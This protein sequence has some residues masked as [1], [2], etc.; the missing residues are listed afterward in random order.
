MPKAVR[1]ELIKFGRE[2]KNIIEQSGY[3]MS[4][5]AEKFSI[6]KTIVYE[7]AK[8]QTM[9]GAETLGAIARGLSQISGKKITV[10]ELLIKTGLKEE[11]EDQEELRTIPNS[12]L[13]WHVK[14]KDNSDRADFWASALKIAADDYES[15]VNLENNDSLAGSVVLP[16][17]RSQMDILIGLIN[18]FA[19][20]HKLEDT[21]DI[22][23]WL[24]DRFPEVRSDVKDSMIIG[25]AEILA[26]KRLPYQDST[27]YRALIDPLAKALGYDNDDDL[28]DYC[29]LEA[30]SSPNGT[31]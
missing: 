12:K 9:P 6:P 23:S 4:A 17:G 26:H 1:P 3:S 30:E 7:A 20:R 25:L 11:Q 29:G 28:L 31:V 15:F 18:D 24:L 14:Q 27:E 19:N 2:I 21:E 8:G 5:F 16:V 13:L 22:A 10:D